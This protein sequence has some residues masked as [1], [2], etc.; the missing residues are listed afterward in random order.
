MPS[1]TST[2]RDSK[3]ACFNRLPRRRSAGWMYQ[4]AI[5]G[6]LGLRRQGETFAM[7]PSI[8]AMWPAYS[9]QWRTGRSRFRITVLNPEHRSR[10]VRAAE[11]DGAPVDP[12]AIPIVDDGRTHE[13]VIV[14]GTPDTRELQAGSVGS[15]QR[16]AS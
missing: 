2:A 7:D 4:T 14:L 8:P 1:A 16:E 3:V 6:L 5:E 13:V 15:A 12:R 11:M 9:I 10:G